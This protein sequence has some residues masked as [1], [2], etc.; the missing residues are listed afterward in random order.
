VRLLALFFAVLVAGA[1]LYVLGLARADG[2]ISLAPAAEEPARLA[3]FTAAISLAA[4]GLILIGRIVA[5]TEAPAASVPDATRSEA[6]RRA[7]LGVLGIAA[8]GAALLVAGSFAA[9]RKDPVQGA[10]LFTAGTLEALAAT[11]LIPAALRSPRASAV[12]A[13]ALSLAAL[14]LAVATAVIVLGGA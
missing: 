1:L 4:A 11:C 12:L 13:P 2:G 6:P 14:D 7:A 3:I 5:R 10:V 9:L 8:V